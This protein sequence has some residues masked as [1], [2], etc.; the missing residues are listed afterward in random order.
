MG[1]LQIENKVCYMLTKVKD[2]NT[3]TTTAEQVRTIKAIVPFT[4]LTSRL[5][6][7]QDLPKLLQLRDPMP[8]LKATNSFMKTTFN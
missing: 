3:L 2:L 8:I 1:A 5:I 7:I 6:F 4:M